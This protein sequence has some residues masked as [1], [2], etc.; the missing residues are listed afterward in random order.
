M[1]L[2]RQNW[3]TVTLSYLGFDRIILTNFSLCKIL[4]HVFWLVLRKYGWDL[5]RSLHWLPIPERIDFK[6]LLLTF[7]SLND[8]ALPYI[9]ELLV[10]YRPTR[11]LCSADKGLNTTLKPMVTELFR[12]LLL[13][14]GIP[15]QSVYAHV[16]S[17]ALSNQKSKHFF[18]SVLFSCNFILYFIIFIVY[19]FI[20]Y[21]LYFYF[22]FLTN[23]VKFQK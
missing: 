7:K 23:T 18:L 16:V 14:Y 9:E 8:V 10:R 3:T 5:K 11:T 12:T 22:L 6:L 20:H 4:L 13:R 17:W 21:Y 15:C 2:L 1:H 19:L